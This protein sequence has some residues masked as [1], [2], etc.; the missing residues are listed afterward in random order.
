MNKVAL[1]DQLNAAAD[2]AASFAIAHGVP[3]SNKA[4]AWVGHTCI[5][6]NK[7]GFYDIF[8]L[9][10]Q[11]LFKDIA[12]FDIAII[13]AQRYTA[14]E[15]KT[16]EKVIQLEGVYSKYH[17]DML[18]YLHC[19][20]GAKKRHEYDVMAILEDKFQFC[21]IRAKSVRD[22]ISIFKRLK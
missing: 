15:F 7:D 20:R 10:K 16:I 9:D 18:H 12:V 8:S 1:I 11:I 2:N 6:K 4:G 19:L 21:E 17:T 13:V 3:I 22:N 5:V 14:G